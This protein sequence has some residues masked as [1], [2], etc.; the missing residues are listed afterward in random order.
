MKMDFDTFPE[1]KDIRLEDGTIVTVMPPG[2]DDLLKTAQA[3]YDKLKLILPAEVDGEIK[4]GCSSEPVMARLLRAGLLHRIADIAGSAIEFH[5]P[6]QPM[7]ALLM[8]QAALESVAV[9]YSLYEEIKEAVDSQDVGAAKNCIKAFLHASKGHNYA[10]PQSG[11]ILRAVDRLEHLVKGMRAEY[12]ILNHVAYPTHVGT[13][14]HYRGVAGPDRIGIT[15]F[16]PSHSYL[17]PKT[18]V[19]LL[20][21]L[22]NAVVQVD[23]S[24]V[25]VLAEFRQRSDSGQNKEDGK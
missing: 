7:R 8:T 25:D 6:W 10:D 15:T 21:E 23:G 9:Y 13:L 16:S 3:A 12:D 14:V 4:R 5:S 1:L 18:G 17:L 20:T 11:D 22:L 19:R 2:F 24:L